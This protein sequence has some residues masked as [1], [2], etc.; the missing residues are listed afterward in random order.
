MEGSYH[1]I[2]GDGTGF[3]VKI[4]RFPLNSPVRADG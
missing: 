3:D 4:P 1:T 2:G